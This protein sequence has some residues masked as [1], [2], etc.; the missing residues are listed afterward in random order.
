MQKTSGAASWDVRE[1]L[2]VG[3]DGG[4][5]GCRARIADASGRT[6]GAGHSAPAAVRLGIER[7]L[8]AVLAAAR[9]ACT[10]AGLP[11]DAL[12]KL[13][14][15]VGLAGIGRKSVLEQLK[16]R[17]HPFRSI[18]YV[19]D[20]TIACVGAHGGRDG[21]IVIVGTGSVGLARKD[22][23]EIRVGGYG[24]PVSDEG[25]GADLGLRAIR[26][27]LRACDGRHPPTNLTRAVMARFADDPFEI[28]AWADHATATDYAQFAPLV[29]DHAE[30]GDGLAREIATNAAGEID[31]LA[32]RL[33]ARGVSCIALVGGV[34][35]RIEPWLAEDV[36]R[37]LVPSEGDAVDGA[38]ILAR[39]RAEESAP[40]HR[41]RESKDAKA[42]LRT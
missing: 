23:R 6:L 14:G 10:N 9:A 17:P 1:P 15:V 38:L 32:R 35:R 20:A 39:G 13:H 22:G 29:M 26:C 27:S 28:V 7:A 25:S 34:A 5:S 3:V 16:G 11:S 36:R 2:F 21:G 18:A 37:V 31:S 12:A 8:A 30:S 41:A 40:P 4:G 19:N 33:V 24:F 42:S